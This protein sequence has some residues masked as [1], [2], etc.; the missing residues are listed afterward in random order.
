MKRVVFFTAMLLMCSCEQSKTKKIDP[1]KNVSYDVMNNP[2]FQII[3]I[4]SCEYVL[5]CSQKYSGSWASGLTHKGNCRF[6]VK[7]SNQINK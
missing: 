5:Y 7:R 3:T 2:N 4:D 6:C 1:T